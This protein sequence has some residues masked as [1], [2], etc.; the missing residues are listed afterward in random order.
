MYD[1]WLAGA[2]EFPRGWEEEMSAY[3]AQGYLAEPILGRRRDFLDGENKNEIVN[4]PIQAAGSAIMALA[5]LN[6]VGQIPCEYAGPHTGLI[7]QCHD[8]LVLEVP[9]HDAERVARILTDSMHQTFDAL[10]GVKFTGTANIAR[11]WKDA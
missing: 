1:A 2:S 5:T 9:E 3:R 4:F 10:P 8:A 11:N 7:N 6:L